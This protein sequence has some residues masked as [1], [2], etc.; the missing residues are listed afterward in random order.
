[1]TDIKT[2]K[3]NRF[4]Q[5]ELR[6]LSSIAMLA[7]LL[8]FSV[9][10]TLLNR[11]LDWEVW[12]IPFIVFGVVLSLVL[13]LTKKLP[14]RARIYIFGFFL[15][16]DAFYYTVKIDTV[17][18]S[19]ALNVILLFLFAI[20]GELILVTAAF[21]SEAVSIGMHFIIVASEDRLKL[22]K[23]NITRT[24]LQFVIIFLAFILV[25]RIMNAIKTARKKYEDRLLQLQE[26][27]NSANRFLANVSHEIR[28]PINAVIGLSTVIQ[29]DVLSPEAR[30]NLEAISEAG[31]RVAS[32]IGDILDYTEIDMKKLSVSNEV[33]QIDS[34]MGD[35][36]AQIRFYEDHGLELVIDV[37]PNV[38]A[39]LIGDGNKIKKIITHLIDNGF[40]FTKEGGVCLRI[41]SI[42]KSYGINLVIEVTDTGIG[43][44]EEEI[45]KISDRFYQS[46]TASST[47]VGGLGLGIPIVNGFTSAMGGFLS[48]ESEP[49]KG[50]T[51]RASIPQKV[52]D[53]APC[54]SVVENEE[55]LIAGFLGFM[56]M[57][58][59]RV[60]E[61]YIRM[62]AHIV[63]GLGVTFQRVQSIEELQKIIGAYKITHLFV[64]PGEYNEYK[65]YIDSLAS[66]VKVAVIADKGSN[67]RAEYGITV[68]P[69]PFYG[70][71]IANFLSNFRLESEVHAGDRMVC[72]GLRALVV[73]D[74]PMNLLVARGIFESYKMKVVTVTSGQEA[75]DICQKKD[76]DIVFM[77]HM[78]PGMD[79]VEAMKR[80]RSVSQKKSKDL[81]I[82]ALTANA[83]S[84]AK[85]MFLSEGFDGFVP[86]PIEIM[87]LERVL[88]H[89]LPKS[90][91]KYEPIEKESAKTKAKEEP[92]KLGNISP[93]FPLPVHAERDEKE[94]EFKSL[95]GC[96][97]NVKE[98]IKNSG[99]NI[100]FYKQVLS[101][102]ANGIVDKIPLLDKYYR[103]GMWN[104]YAIKAHAVKSTSKLIGADNLSDM[105]AILERAAKDKN[106]KAI[107]ELHEAFI[108]RY[109]D[110]LETVKTCVFETGERTDQEIF[111]FK[112]GGGG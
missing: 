43:M 93:I 40:K 80:I 111:E 50:T 83:I 103:K 76:C 9:I 30:K 59:P 71:Q 95:A 92:V 87:E 60:R 41:Y 45:D 26:E 97:I 14:E 31:H 61:F 63:T 35:M 29:N 74:E 23:S 49:G 57:G 109:R 112:P 100:A 32:Q 78:M 33:Y 54:Y 48:I 16:F 46:E 101:E 18:D 81:C 13:H 107:R 102:Y 51:V 20:T 84:S 39:E 65:E 70:I 12:M 4:L 3:D 36:L 1:M 67:L 105:A 17:Y 108:K 66:D 34:I 82:V 86:K 69:K 25:I 94:N 88:R 22:H 62:I 19:S 5:D 42:P 44:T 110:T 6:A 104:D 52:E 79:G 91:I 47:A 38:P 64:G 10:L 89:V 53:P 21:A 90:F 8:F 106:E 99:N 68:I 98:G 56:N 58:D 96:G 37:E 27:N 28:T 55:C 7:M 85:E 75:I 77:D 11:M 2:K 24:I 15:S 73:D 72:P